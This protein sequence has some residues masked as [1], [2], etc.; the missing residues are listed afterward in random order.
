[1]ELTLGI[2]IGAIVGVVTAL[3]AQKRSWKWAAL[4][5]AVFIVCVAIADFKSNLGITVLGACLVAFGLSKVVSGQ[6]L[7]KTKP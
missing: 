4:L 1:M 3:V 2:V 6:V 5:G 7:E